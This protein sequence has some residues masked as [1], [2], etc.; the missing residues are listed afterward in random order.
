MPLRLRA[1]AFIA[2]PTTWLPAT[3]HGCVG[4]PLTRALSAVTPAPRREQFSVP[5]RSNGSIT[6]DIFH[7][8]KPSPPVIVYLPSGPLVTLG[9]DEEDAVITAL[10]QHSEATI[11]RINYRASTI[12]KYPTPV[13][14]V[15]AGFDWLRDTFIRDE[16]NRSY[17]AR[18]GVCGQ[19]L[20][21]SLAAMLALTECRL[22]ES[23]IGAAAINNPLADWVFPEE[24]PF[25]GTTELPEPLAAEDTAL[26]ADED[27]M[28]SIALEATSDSARKSR[29]RSKKE[30]PM[31]AWQRYSANFVVP[32]RSLTLARDLLFRKTENYF[33]PFAS[34]IHYFR[35]PVAQ[36]V[37]PH[38]EDTSASLQPDIL[39]DAEIQ[40]T[41][42]HYTAGGGW[43]NAAPELPT[44]T[45][46]RAYMRGYPPAGSKINFPAWNVT[47]GLES[48]L[49]DQSKE[50]TKMLRRS[51]ARHTLKGH[52]GRTRWHDAIEKQMY[53]EIAEERVLLNDCPGVGLWTG[54]AGDFHERHMHDI[55]HWLKGQLELGAS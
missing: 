49:S 37:L 13:H 5:C 39:H 23:G 25:I 28:S 6:L 50:I 3:R 38:S 24:L 21:G 54:Q 8:S 11:A 46:C 41:L 52:A 51:I 1:N 22:G 44:L 10:Q 27:P 40:M 4:A 31:T 29:L 33:D 45:R 48:P 9:P 14:D 16:F 15:L 19:L 18:L 55:G 2:R 43:A 35:S 53:E 17:I 42:N 12:H 7:A 34:P 20:G 32:V 47:T 30:I 36:L 26:P